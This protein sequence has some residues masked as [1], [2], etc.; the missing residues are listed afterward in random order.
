MNCFFNYTKLII[1][2]SLALSSC[3]GGGGNES[4]KPG[5]PGTCKNT[6]E[7]NVVTVCEDI[8][9]STMWTSDKVYLV[10]STL[11]VKAALTIQPKTVIKFKPRGAIVVT[12]SGVVTAEGS[13]SQPIVFTSIKDDAHGGD[14]NRDGTATKPSKK[15][16]ANIVLSSNGSSFNFCEFYYGGGSSLGS[17]LDLATFKSTIKN[18]VFAHNDGGSVET[19]TAMTGVIDASRAEVGTEIL[20]NTFYDNSV[21]LRISGN[22][23]IDESNTFH[24]SSNPITKNVHNSIVLTGNSSNEIATT[25]T[26]SETEVP[27]V[28]AGALRVNVGAALTLTDDVV[29]KMYDGL[30]NVTVNGS[31]IADAAAGHSIVFTSFK[32]D[33]HGGD[34]NGDGAA[35]SP[36]VGDWGQLVLRSND[37]VFV[38]NEFYF[39]GQ[40][41]F[42]NPLQATIDLGDFR[43]IVKGS[44]FAHNHGGTIA[45]S[46]TNYGVIDASRAAAGTVIAN[47]TFF[48]NSIPLKVNGTFSVDGSNRFSNPSNPTQKNTFN[49]IFFM[50]SVAKAV[51]GNVIWSE[52]EV[53]FVLSGQ[54]RVNAGAS[55]TFGDG[56]VVK[57]LDGGLR[58]EGAL[59]NA[60]GNGV[61]FTSIKDDVR[62]GDTDGNGSLSSPAE[63]DWEGLYSCD[64]GEHCVPVLSSN[65]L[66]DAN[67]PL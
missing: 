46:T 67:S 45:G 6:V 51:T 60:N 1:L 28:L 40:T 55:I 44:I 53:P 14:T 65:I 25:M 5:N 4:T 26:F 15:D 63:G 64:T 17:T 2:S 16:W 39:G 66:Y 54:M 58:N 12:A 38:N 36:S 27:L 3:G 49:G 10:N 52:T 57:F 35:T 42:T 37:S 48:D 31:L 32:D 8:A 50:G 24:D 62:G 19:G 21:P 41:Q 9:S 11:F 29:V 20:R 22:F 30:T 13:S 33:A 43:A 18:S 59:L 23:S 7:N 47:N 61:W 34:T 56:V